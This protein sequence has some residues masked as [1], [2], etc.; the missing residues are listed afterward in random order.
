MFIPTAE[1]IIVGTASMGRL[2]RPS[3]IRRLISLAIDQGF[4]NFDTAPAYGSGC[5]EALLGQVVSS[6]EQITINTKFGLQLPID[7]KLPPAGYIVSKALQLSARKI[8][9]RPFQH[10]QAN[11]LLAAAS[12]SLAASQKLL[13]GKIDVFFAH[14]V[15]ISIMETDQFMEWIETSKNTGK[16]QR[17]GLGG[18]RKQYE[19]LI[20][21]PIWDHV[22]VIQVEAVLG[23]SPQTPPGWVGDVFLHG[24]LGAVPMNQ[25]PESEAIRAAIINAYQEQN[26]SKLVVGFSRNNTLTSFT[27]NQFQ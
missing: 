7:F 15:P 5:M 17:F 22:D 16:F 26:A 19:C 4:I 6:Y 9:K 10:V 13:H 18:Y 1:S 20:K 3:H 8:L 12:K 14:E 27:Q 24:V 25:H 11:E 21:T 23:L 2:N